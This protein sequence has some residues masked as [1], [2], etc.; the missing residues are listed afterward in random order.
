MHKFD[1]FKFAGREVLPTAS[2][3]VGVCGADKI[4]SSPLCGF[5][6]LFLP[7]GMCLGRA[8]GGSFDARSLYVQLHAWHTRS[9]CSVSG[10]RNGF[11]LFQ[12]KGREGRE[13]RDLRLFL[14]LQEG[15]SVVYR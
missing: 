15:V 2:R 10:S 1:N 4:F 8:P 7:S 11:F 9:C 3:F 13:I 5:A 12:G 14:F 6:V